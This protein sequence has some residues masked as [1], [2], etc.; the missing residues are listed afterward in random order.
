MPRRR[1]RGCARSRRGSRTLEAELTEV[2]AE[3]RP[4]R[5]DPAEPAR[6]RV[7]LTARPTRTPSSSARSASARASTSRFATTSSI[8][9]ALGLIETEKAAAGLRLAL[10]LPARRP[11]AG[12]AGPDSLRGRVARSARASPRSCPPVL[13][14]EEPLFGTGF[15]PGEREMIYEVAEGRAVPGR[16][17]R[18]LAGGAACRRDPRRRPAAAALRGDLDLLPARGRARQARTPA[19]SSA[20]I[21]S[22]RS[23]CSASSHPDD[24]GRRAPAPARDRGGDPRRARDSLPRRRHPGRRPRRA[25]GPQVRL[26]GLDP[27][28]GALPR[29]D[30]DLEHDRLPGAPHQLPLPDP[31]RAQPPSR[32]TP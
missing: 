5:C 12:R 11:G 14:R 7:R 32:S 24:S 21:S 10:R 19:E 23:R 9:R 20:C 27:E 31:R 3:S 25:G 17:L 2:E 22:T 30:L 26:R 6:S 28:P 4:A 16:H 15:F 18:G 8:G 29:A 13:V 1:S